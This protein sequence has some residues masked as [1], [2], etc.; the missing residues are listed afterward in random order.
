M[1]N[2]TDPASEVTQTDTELIGRVGERTYADGTH[3]TMEWEGRRVKTITDRQ[4]RPQTFNYN[5]RGQIATVTGAAG[6]VLDKIDYDEAGHITRWTND[7]AVLEYSD[8]DYEGHPRKTKQSRM[9]NGALVDQYT[10]EHAWNVFGD[11]SSWTMP[12]Y[13]EFNSANAWTAS[14]DAQYDD[15]GNVTRLQ[16]T[17]LNGGASPFL[18][19]DFRAAGHPNRRTVTTATGPQ[20]VR[21]YGY[22]TSNGLLN[23]MAVTPNGKLSPGSHFTSHRPPN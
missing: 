3:E 6:V 9:K 1:T 19:A 22:D 20:I 23:E 14:V 13:S 16:R 7:D 2:Y 15:V 11:R 21:T 5:A 8:F 10:Q 4:G 18:D 12:T 17:P